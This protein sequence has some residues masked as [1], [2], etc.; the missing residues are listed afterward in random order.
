MTLRSYSAPASGVLSCHSVPSPHAA[1]IT[2]ADRLGTVSVLMRVTPRREF[3]SRAGLPGTKDRS[4]S[5][6]MLFEA[7]SSFT[8]VA[9]CGFAHPPFR[10]G[11]GRKASTSPVPRRRRFSAIQA[12]RKLLERDLHPLG[13]CAMRAHFRFA[14]E[15]ASSEF[16]SNSV[17]LGSFQSCLRTARAALRQTEG[18]A[19][20]SE[21]ICWMLVKA[22]RVSIAICVRN[23][24]WNSA[25]AVSTALKKWGF[26]AQL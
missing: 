1:L 21:R 11:L 3:P 25:L 2:P 26:L 19:S 9:A 6:D 4:A 20:V 17:E 12:Y 5:A 18:E 8:R 16:V 23:C 13:H 15:S 14:S 10:C 24:F 22:R 7:C